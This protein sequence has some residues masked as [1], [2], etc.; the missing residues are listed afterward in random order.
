MTR[1]V[2]LIFLCGVFLCVNRRYGWGGLLFGRRSACADG[3]LLGTDN[4][5]VN[6]AR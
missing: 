4:G 3:V 1:S 6:G 5:R 2:V